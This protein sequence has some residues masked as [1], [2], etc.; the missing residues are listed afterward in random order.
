MAPCRCDL[1]CYTLHRSIRGTLHPLP[2][3]FLHRNFICLLRNRN[4]R[5]SGKRPFDKTNKIMLYSGENSCAKPAI[6]HHLPVTFEALSR[7]TTLLAECRAARAREI[8]IRRLISTSSVRLC[9][10]IQVWRHITHVR[11][12]GL[13]LSTSFETYKGSISLCCLS[14]H[15]FVHKPFQ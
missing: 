1:S 12:F 10:F 6:L 5:A 4:Y 11:L 3:S 7:L 2:L 8:K 13:F 14:N 9:S 15:Q